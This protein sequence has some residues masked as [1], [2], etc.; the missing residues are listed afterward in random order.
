MVVKLVVVV[1]MFA[2]ILA[3]IAEAAVGRAVY[4]NP[5]YTR[6]AC[7]GTQRGTMVVGVKS[8]LWQG[9]RACGRRLSLILMPATFVLNTLRYE[10]ETHNKQRR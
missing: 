2:H 3:P 9:S 6:S 4:Y 8:N 1:I 10:V 7:Y 5:P